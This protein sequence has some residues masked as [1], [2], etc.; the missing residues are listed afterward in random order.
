[1]VSVPNPGLY[2]QI[3]EK[4]APGW[5][6]GEIEYFSPDRLEA[7]PTLRRRLVAVMGLPHD[8]RMTSA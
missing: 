5:K 2:T 3:G 7:Y 6:R 1:M 4:A 8:L